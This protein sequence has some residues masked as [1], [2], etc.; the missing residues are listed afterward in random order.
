VGAKEQSGRTWPSIFWAR[1]TLAHIKTG[2]FSYI[3][4]RVLTRLCFGGFLAQLPPHHHTL[5]S[6]QTATEVFVYKFMAVLL[7]W[8]KLSKPTRNLP[9]VA[10]TPVSTTWI[11]V[12][13]MSP[14][15]L[16]PVL[17]LDLRISPQIFINIRNDPI[18]LFGTWGR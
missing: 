3:F 7:V 4:I 1:G 13:N 15:L 2:G 11:L 16:M 17:Q 18:M 12:A 14:V 10:L 5:E 6:T 9:P 8:R